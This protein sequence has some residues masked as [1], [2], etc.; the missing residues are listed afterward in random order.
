MFPVV[1]DYVPNSLKTSQVG[2]TTPLHN[3]FHIH[4]SVAFCLAQ[5]TF[6]LC[7]MT[8]SSSVPLTAQ[9]NSSLALGVRLVLILAF[10]A[11]V[12]CFIRWFCEQ[13]PPAAAVWKVR[14]LYACPPSRGS[15]I[16]RFNTKPLD[17]ARAVFGENTQQMNQG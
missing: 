1:M 15:R 4:T 6:R 16:I 13:A 5:I 11:H 12:Y 2:P 17:R 8:G 7:A 9:L 10:L 14:S 3:P